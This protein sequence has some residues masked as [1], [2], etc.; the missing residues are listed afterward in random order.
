MNSK[1]RKIVYFSLAIASA[2]IIIICIV[3]VCNNSRFFEINV[4]NGITMLW[5]VGFSFVL[6]QGFSKYQRKSDIIVKLLQELIN[7]IDES[8]TCIINQDSTKKETL[9]MQ[10]RQIQ[11]Q[12]SLLANH[13]KRFGID[14]DMQ[15]IKEKFSEYEEIISEHIDDIEYLSHSQ[16]QLSRPIKLIRERLYKAIL[17]L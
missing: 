9:L 4:F 12:I 14:G 7:N 3:N 2:I 8:K 6:T 15:F 10:N 11:Q 5:T 1:Y 17:N 13:A 16:T